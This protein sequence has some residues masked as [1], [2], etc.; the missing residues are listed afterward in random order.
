VQTVTLLALTSGDP[1]AA[2]VAVR[3]AVRTADERLVADVVMP[4]EQRLLATLAQPRVYAVLLGAFAAFAVIIAGVGL[5]GLLSYAVS[6]R[7][8]ELAIRAALGAARMDLLRLV[9]RQG[10]GVTL[11][12]IVAGLLASTWLTR[13]LS[14]QLHGVGPHDA[15]TFVLVPVLI[16]VVSMLACLLPARRAARVDAFRVLRGG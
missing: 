7:S 9:L 4:L 13:L 11:S 8:R 14:A 10:L 6:Q 15:I 3:R 5:F 16:L 1:R 2:A 12:G